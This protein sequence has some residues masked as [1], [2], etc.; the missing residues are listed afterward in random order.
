[1]DDVTPLTGKE[2]TALWR[3]LLAALDVRSKGQFFL[4]AQGQVQALVPHNLMVC[5]RLDPQGMPKHI[6]TLPGVPIE[7]STLDALTHPQSGLVARVAQMCRQADLSQITWFDDANDK[8]SPLNAMAP[9][10]QA[11]RLGQAMFQYTGPMVDGS[12]LFAFFMLRESPTA[13]MQWMLRV[14]QPSLRMAFAR[15]EYHTEA[16]RP[17]GATEDDDTELTERQLEILHWV[18]LGKTNYEISQIL[19]I[20]ALTVK[21]HMQKLFKKLNVHN[22]AQAVA[23]VMDMR[24]PPASR[25]LGDQ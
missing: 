1:M 14:L 3:A 2:Q 23:R 7:P 19:D 24:L 10:M 5:V 20:S 16:V 8:S 17:G 13:A 11:L 15:V 22:R 9:D 12:A 21:N 25:A 6:E 18:K 4:W